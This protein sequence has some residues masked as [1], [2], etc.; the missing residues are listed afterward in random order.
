MSV[1]WLIFVCIA[2]SFNLLSQRLR[3]H[4]D[5]SLYTFKN[6]Y[7]GMPFNAGITSAATSSAWTIHN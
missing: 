1:C 3:T 2:F 5:S 4:K 6:L 7:Q